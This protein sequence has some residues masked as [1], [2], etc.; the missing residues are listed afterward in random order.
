MHGNEKVVNYISSLFLILSRDLA[1]FP[2]PTTSKSP[3]QTFV[4]H[5]TPRVGKICR[6]R[7]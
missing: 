5:F 2:C 1:E 3:Q 7:R 6:G 4:S